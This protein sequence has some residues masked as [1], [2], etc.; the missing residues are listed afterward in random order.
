MKFSIFIACLILSFTVNAQLYKNDV[1]RPNNFKTPHKYPSI[2][3]VDTSI[4]IYHD[5]NSVLNLSQP[6]LIYKGNNNNGFN[7]YEITSYNMP[8]IKPDSTVAFTMP[9]K[10]LTLQ[11][12][13]TD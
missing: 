11:A 3:F 1:L 8:L 12:E 7:A 6:Q 9:V 13:A 2:R 10:R 4:I 5:H